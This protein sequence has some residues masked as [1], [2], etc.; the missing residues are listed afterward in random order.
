MK[1][2]IAT[3]AHFGVVHACCAFSV[4]EA[5]VVCQREGIET[6][7]EILPKFQNTALAR[8]LLATRFM[9]SDCTDLVFIDADEGFNPRALWQILQHDVD[10]VAGVPP[11]HSDT[12]SYPVKLTGKSEGGLLEAESV[13]TGFLRLRRNVL[14]RMGGRPAVN[15]SRQYVKWFEYTCEGINDVGHDV[16]FV[17]RW[18]ALGGRVWV[19]PNI[20][21]IH[22]AMKDYRGHLGSWL[23]SGER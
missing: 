6:A 14:E 8:N 15:G 9:S 3:P 5:R 21:F 11:L 16:S 4:A 1:A 12:E 19:D 2:F 10:M 17:R 22:T 13:G 18:K 23:K 7:W 20:E